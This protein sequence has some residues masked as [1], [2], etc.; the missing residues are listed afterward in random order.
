MSGMLLF[1]KVRGESLLQFW[2]LLVVIFLNFQS[3][4]AAAEVLPVLMTGKLLSCNEARLGCWLF[5]T[6]CGC[7]FKE[8]TSWCGCWSCQQLS[9]QCYTRLL[10]FAK[11]SRVLAIWEGLL[12]VE[13]TVLL[14]DSGN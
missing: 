8:R 13:D 12:K 11:S 7:S 14:I 3:L 4:Q 2:N 5:E 1:K 10:A 9:E 6:Q